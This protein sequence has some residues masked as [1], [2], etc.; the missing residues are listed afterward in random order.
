MLEKMKK[1]FNGFLV[2]PD[3]LEI[4]IISRVFWKRHLLFIKIANRQ[5]MDFF[6]IL[7]VTAF[8]KFWCSRREHGAQP[9]SV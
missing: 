7:F 5:L 4:L 3:Y 1:L 8:E 6:W 9:R 2:Y